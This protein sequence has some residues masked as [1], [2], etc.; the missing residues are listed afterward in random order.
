MAALPRALRS[1]NEHDR[2]V[3]LRGVLLA[4]LVLALLSLQ[5][6]GAAEPPSRRIFTCVDGERPRLTSDRPIAECIDR[7]QRVLNADGSVQARSC[8]PR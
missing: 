7:E 4:A 3:A 2:A 8:R 6:A 5:P 1:L